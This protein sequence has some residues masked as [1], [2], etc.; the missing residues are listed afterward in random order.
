MLAARI[1]QLRLIAAPAV[2][3]QAGLPKHTLTAVA[4]EKVGEKGDSGAAASTDFI[5]CPL[6]KHCLHLTTGLKQTEWLLEMA[7][8]GDSITAPSVCHSTDSCADISDEHVTCTQ[9]LMH[10]F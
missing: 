6:C 2:A 4:A 10:G 5:G 7:A 1:W 9:A 8:S 3:A